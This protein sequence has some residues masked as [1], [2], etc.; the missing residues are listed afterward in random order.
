MLQQLNKFFVLAL[1]MIS[2]SAHATAII[3]IEDLRKE[4][5]IGLFQSVSGS[6]DAS[7]GNRDRDYYTFTPFQSNL[8]GCI[9]N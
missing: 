8:G 7:R 5:E 3:N 4:G 1:T 9:L 6:V 2:V